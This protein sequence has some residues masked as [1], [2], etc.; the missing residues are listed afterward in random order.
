MKQRL[1]TP[2]GSLFNRSLRASS[3]NLKCSCEASDTKVPRRPFPRFH[4]QADKS[5]I[6]VNHTNTLMKKYVPITR[7]SFIFCVFF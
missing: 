7:D 1:L 3:H 4:I 6:V 2:T 5:Y